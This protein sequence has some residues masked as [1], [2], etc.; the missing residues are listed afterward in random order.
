MRLLTSGC[1]EPWPEHSMCPPVLFENST[2]WGGSCENTGPCISSSNV[3][4]R[5]KVRK[6]HYK[7]Y[8]TNVTYFIHI[9][10]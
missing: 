8:S 9:H 1:G 7:R 10:I 4:E 6:P 3:P 5:F 2:L